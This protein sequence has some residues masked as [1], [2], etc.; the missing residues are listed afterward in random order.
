M[1]LLD[2][3]HMPP[4]LS[5]VPV[6]GFAA[7]LLV[8]LFSAGPPNAAAASVRECG[9]MSSALAYNITARVVSCREARRVVR[10]WNLGAA[11]QGG[12]GYSRGLNCRYRDTGYEAG[13]IRCTGNRR[14]VV[15][16][17]TGS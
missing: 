9:D 12:G 8:M 6:V 14:R 7:T 13:D 1:G 10:A 15:R 2:R 16:W 3:A 5:R 11:R 4:R 17:Q